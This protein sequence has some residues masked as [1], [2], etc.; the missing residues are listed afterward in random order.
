MLPVFCALLR[1]VSAA[2]AAILLIASLLFVA[3][4]A[5]ANTTTTATA[6][7]EVACD[8]SETSLVLDGLPPTP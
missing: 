2:P 7:V 6:T 1:R 8:A 3:L 4:P 5:T